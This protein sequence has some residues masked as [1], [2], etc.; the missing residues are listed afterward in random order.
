MYILADFCGIQQIFLVFS[1]AVCF[2]ACTQFICL[3]R[4][5]VAEW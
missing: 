5:T 3:T 4:A 1:L 2:N